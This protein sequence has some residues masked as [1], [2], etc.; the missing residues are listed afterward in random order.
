M[1]L[2]S[3]SDAGRREF[4]AQK[5]PRKVV[6]VGDSPP[7]EGFGIDPKVLDR[8]D[9]QLF[10]PERPSL[11]PELF[12]AADVVEG[13]KGPP[14]H[15]FVE[16]MLADRRQQRVVRPPPPGLL[17]VLRLGRGEVARV[18]IGSE[19]GAKRCKRFT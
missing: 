3:C 4:M 6:S 18:Q 10:D 15:L 1:R 17:A 5:H 14:A 11:V 8:L 16:S 12:V 19:Q 2:F 13:A 7:R 9:A